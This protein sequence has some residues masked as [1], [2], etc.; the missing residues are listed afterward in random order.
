MTTPFSVW[1]ELS[2]DVD[3]EAVEPVTELFNRH[4]FGAG[5]VVEEPFLQEADGDN[6]RIDLSRPVTMRTFVKHDDLSEDTLAELRST[7][8][9]LGRMRP[10]GE[11][12]VAE[13]A[14]E[15]WANAWR[16]HYRPIRVG[17]RIVVRPPWQ[18]YEPINGEVVMVLD[19]GMAFGTGSHPS[20]R[21]CL[22]AVEDFV[23]PGMRVFDVGAGSGILAIAALLLGASCADAV[24]IED[25]AV[26]ATVENAV[27]N[28]VGGRISSE[29]GSAGPDQPFTGSYPLVIAN[30]I[31]RVLVE[32]SESLVA[33]LEPSGVLI[34][35]GIV[36]GKEPMVRRAFDGLGLS[37]ERRRMSEDWIC[38]VYR[39]P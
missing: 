19:P 35:A 7:L 11:L 9:H 27:A 8:W 2:I 32:L 22:V 24:D 16:E 18:E 15:D 31:S 33:A 34:L 30:I 21:L 1:L 25:V 5:L 28:G 10:V 38:L 29:L 36:E 14:E 17:N 3:H 4:G 39:K 23:Q 37:L 13:R 20:T 6:M 26:V 12:V